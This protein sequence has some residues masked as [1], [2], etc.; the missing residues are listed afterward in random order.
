MPPSAFL[1]SIELPSSPKPLANPQNLDSEKIKYHLS[2]RM[3]M[4]LSI[5][6]AYINNSA[7]DPNQQD[8]FSFM[9]VFDSDNTGKI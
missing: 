8:V 7:Y 2:L 4:I 9:S 5:C 6:V 1:I 3:P